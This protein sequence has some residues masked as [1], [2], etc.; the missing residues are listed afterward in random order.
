VRF[1]QCK[2]IA[3]RLGRGPIWRIAQPLAQAAFGPAHR[4]IQRRRRYR[5]RHVERALDYRQLGVEH[6]PL[7]MGAWAGGGSGAGIR[8]WKIRVW[9]VRGPNSVG[10]RL[11][12]PRLLN[13]W[14]APAPLPK[15]PRAKLV[16]GPKTQTTANTAAKTR[17]MI[18]FLLLLCLPHARNLII[19]QGTTL[20]VLPRFDRPCGLRPGYPRCPAPWAT[21]R[22]MPHRF[23]RPHLLPDDRVECGSI[24][25]VRHWNAY[26]EVLAKGQM[27][28]ACLLHSLL[29]GIQEWIVSERADASD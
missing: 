5:R 11:K 10:F 15:P 26:A 29:K 13:P 17:F 12:A 25:G 21:G 16:V 18:A 22:R 19:Q 14:I 8:F 24:P 9:G 4:S 6:G 20:S 3:P 2:V 27:K 28:T 23:S 7:M 1:P